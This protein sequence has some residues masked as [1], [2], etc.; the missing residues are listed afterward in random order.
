MDHTETKHASSVLTD[1]APVNNSRL[2]IYSALLPYTSNGS[3][4]SRSLFSTTSRKKPVSLDDVL[5][6]RWLDS[7]LSTSPTRKKTNL[8]ST[9]EISPSAHDRDVVYSSW[10]VILFQLIFLS[11]FAVFPLVNFVFFGSTNIHLHFHRLRK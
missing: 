5:S 4:F 3:V 9:T 6:A 2:G 8:D 10:K 11:T 7:M 1:S